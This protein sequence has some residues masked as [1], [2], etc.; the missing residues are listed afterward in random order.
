ML[1][2]TRFVVTN[3]LGVSVGWSPQKR[4][5]DGTTWLYRRPAALGAHAHRAGLGRV[6]VVAR[7]DRCSGGSRPCWRAWCLSIPLSVLTSRRSL[8]A[9]ARKLGLFLT[10]EE[11]APP[12]ELVSLRAQ[13]KIHELTDDTAPRRPHAGLAEA[14]LD[15]Y[16]NAI[17]VSLLREKQLNPIYAEQLA[18][19]GAGSPQVRALGEKLLA[20]GPDKLTPAERMAVMADERVMVWLH[21]QA[22]LRPTKNSRR[23]GKPRFANSAGRM[24]GNRELRVVRIF[25][26]F[27]RLLGVIFVAPPGTLFVKKPPGF[28][29]ERMLKGAG[30][31]VQS[32]CFKVELPPGFAPAGNRRENFPENFLRLG[33]RE[34]KARRGGQRAGMVGSS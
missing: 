25:L 20:D 19:L 7:T 2:H 34:P 11:T 1:W 27:T 23:G 15:P 30:V 9:R 28:I 33:C 17:H 13:M 31:G 8:G 6:H 12:P 32:G 21:Q 24:S 22:W 26:R 10:P 4:A 18:K 14:V 3:L 16:V 29:H 5:A